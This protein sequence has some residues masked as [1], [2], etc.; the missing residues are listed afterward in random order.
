[1][2]IARCENPK[3][4]VYEYYGGRGI[5]VC[6]RWKDFELFIADMGDKPSAKHSLERIDNEGNYE[7]G[8]CV[9]ATRAAQMRNTRRNVWVTVGGHRMTLIDA[10]TFVGLKPITVYTRRHR[11][12]PECAWFRPTGMPLATF[13][14]S[15]TR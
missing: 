5:K 9:W 2:I 7:P 11:G 15:Q 1:M 14:A 4:S 13:M 3:S 12:E 6:E 10:A 8:N